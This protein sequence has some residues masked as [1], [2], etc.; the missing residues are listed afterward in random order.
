MFAAIDPFLSG[1]LWTTNRVWP[2]LLHARLCDLRPRFRTKSIGGCGFRAVARNGRVLLASDI[3]LSE[4]TGRLVRVRLQTWH[5]VILP[6]DPPEPYGILLCARTLPHAGNE[7][8]YT[9]RLAASSEEPFDLAL[10]V[11]GGLRLEFH[12]HTA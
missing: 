2:L 4:L 8:H 12:R 9:T 10:D 5:K 11:G 7:P 3:F 1:P 6:G